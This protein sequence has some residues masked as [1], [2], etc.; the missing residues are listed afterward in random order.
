MRIGIAFALA[1]T[2][3]CA[4]EGSADPAGTVT[5]VRTLLPTRVRRLTN[6]EYDASVWALVGA[7]S[8]AA[9]SGFPRDSTQK[10]GF[11]VNDQ[12]TVSPLLAGLLDGAAESVAGGARDSGWLATLSPCADTATQAEACARDFIEGFAAKAYRRALVDEDIEP[13]I[14]LFRAGSGDGGTYEEGI[15]L[16]VRAILQSPSFL[17][18]TELGD[19]AAANVDGSFTL[20]PEEAASVLSYWATAGPPDPTLLENKGSLLSAEGR[21]QQARRLLSMAA[22][23]RRLQTFVREWLGI[24]HI[25]EVGKDSNIY[26][27]FAAHRN[28]IAAESSSF[29]E[30][31]LGASASLQELFGAEW[32]IAGSNY[33]A[34]DE[35]IGAYYDAY[36]G[37]SPSGTGRTALRGARGG[38]RVGILNQPAFLSRFAS[39]TA[40]NPVARGVALMRRLTCVELP[41]PVELDIDVIPPLPDPTTPKTTRA[42]Y[43]LH[44]SDPVCTG[45]HQAI[46]NFGFAFEAYD[47]AGAF[48]SNREELVETTSGMSRLPVD[49][50]TT[51]SGTGT[52][53]DAQYADS[54]A[55]ARTLANS[56]TVRSCMARQAFRASSG[57]ST[58]DLRGAEDAFVAEWRELS[59]DQRSNLRETWVAFA[60]SRLFVERDP[61][62]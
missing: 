16:V 30:E 47:G 42:L 57:S 58:P 24:D 4:V 10:L 21:E 37:L 1:L 5:H 7:D 27:S 36:Y 32:T 20:T 35:E 13:L 61:R 59:L 62:P 38:V 52:D 51:V 14:A 33:G 41:S 56:E 43:S 45:C 48:R 9:V 29:I 19:G 44:A 18:V 50:A 34:T 3:G 40:S 11:T 60:K 12:Q 2:A 54:N 31:V 55:L 15:A 26:P 17:Y 6:A 39:A 46:D 22:G 8:V 23:R 53:L 49:T 28:A 25:A